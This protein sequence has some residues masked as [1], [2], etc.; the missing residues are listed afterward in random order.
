MW[1]LKSAVL[2]LSTVKVTKKTMVTAEERNGKTNRWSSVTLVP[3]YELKIYL[4]DPGLYSELP[5]SI[6]VFSWI[7]EIQMGVIYKLG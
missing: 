3:M 6:S 4:E 2:I 1:E 5:C 7:S